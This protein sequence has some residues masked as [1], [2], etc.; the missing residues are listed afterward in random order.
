MVRS[1]PPNLNP[2]D[3][4]VL[5]MKGYNHDKSAFLN[6]D[7]DTKQSEETVCWVLLSHNLQAQETN[8]MLFGSLQAQAINGLYCDAQDLL[9]VHD[10]YRMFLS[11]LSGLGVCRCSFA[12]TFRSLHP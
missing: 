12:T 9:A 4:L 3:V 11:A 6:S 7:Q 5:V 8:R 2:P 10:K 1:D